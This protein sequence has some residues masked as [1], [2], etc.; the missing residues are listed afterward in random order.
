MIGCLKQTPVQ[1]T[2]N[3]NDSYCKWQG[4]CSN[5]DWLHA[6][7]GHRDVAERLLWLSV[8]KGRA[9]FLLK[10]LLDW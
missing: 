1:F 6:A 7:K 4:M 8:R 3:E 10:L 9:S 2:K 5:D